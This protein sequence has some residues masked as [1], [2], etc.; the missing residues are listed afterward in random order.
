[1]DIQGYEN[2]KIFRNGAVLSKG[3][4]YKKPRFL[5]QFING[6]GYY[7]VS[8]YKEKGKPEPKGIH[9]LLGLHYIPNPDKKRCIDHINRDRLD[10][11]LENLRWATHAENRVNTGMNPRNKTGETHITIER[12]NRFRVRM[13]KGTISGNFKT[14][15]EA[16]EFRDANY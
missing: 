9:R 2:Y 12:K 6:V 5:K 7:S 10:N 14:L 15:E 1:M 11:R 8:L 16:I 3:S 13:K 4:K